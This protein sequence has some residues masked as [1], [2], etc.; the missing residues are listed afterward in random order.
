MD[1]D[2]FKKQCKNQWRNPEDY[3]YV[4]INIRK[5]AGERVMTGIC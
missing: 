1:R 3:G 5:P 4:F 2:E